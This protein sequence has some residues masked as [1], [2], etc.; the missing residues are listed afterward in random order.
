MLSPD[1]VTQ[2]PE[3]GQNYDRYTYAFNNPLL[4]TDLNGFQ[5]N[6]NDADTDHADGN[7][8][9]SL[10]P[11]CPNI[12]VK[13]YGYDTSKPFAANVTLINIHEPFGN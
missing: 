2:A 3:N 12:D 4:F 9:S 1:P 6:K 5:A 8:F 7:N 11:R 13:S 10:S